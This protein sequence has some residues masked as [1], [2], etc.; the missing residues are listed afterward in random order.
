M[1]KQWKHWETLILGTPR[2]LQMM[3]TTMNLKD[4]CSFEEKLWQTYT[5]FLKVETLL[6]WK[7]QYNQSYDFSSC[8]VW[9]WQL[10]HK[11]WWAMNNWWFWTLVLDK[12]VESDLDCKETHPV[13]LKEINP[14]Y[15]WKNQCWNWTS[16][17]LANWCE[18]WFIRKDP[19]TGQD[20]RQEE[21]GWQ[22]MRWFDG[23]TNLMDVSLPKLQDLVKNS[24][25]WR[26]AVHGVAMSPTWVSDWTEHT[27]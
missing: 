20:W 9:M 22:R 7:F 4:A 1:G 13:I 15:F 12:S 6:C 23:I 8:H 18:E 14:E 19:V 24:E 25:P 10:H 16:N 3:T 27:T 26:A 5:N 17:T 21:R 2:S 11:E